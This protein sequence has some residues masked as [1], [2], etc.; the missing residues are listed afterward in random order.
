MGAGA[1]LTLAVMHIFVWWKDRAARASLAFS[2]FAIAVAIFA[3]LELAL[4]RAQTPKHFG[5]IMRWIHVALWVMIASLVV[6]VRLY[7]RP[8]R[9]WLAYVVIGVRTLS[10][11]LNFL[12]SPNINYRQITA[13]GHIRFLGESVSVANGVVPNPWIVVA[14]FS[15]V[16]LLIFVADAT[17]TAWRR[18][19][20][21]QAL[22]VGGSI[23]FFISLGTAEGVVI[24]WGIISMPIT[25]SLFCQGLVVAMA[26][27]LSYDLIRAGRLAQQLQASEASCA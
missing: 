26:Y 16:L 15:L 17:S 23:L 6:F 24:G 14:H 8:G 13:L 21:R 1:C 4:M 22:V 18:G 20:H 2:V 7:L 11:I 25:V 9:R 12:F 3:A 19:N 10:L 27:Q 5:T